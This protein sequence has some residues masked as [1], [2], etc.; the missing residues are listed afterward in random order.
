MD[1]IPCDVADVFQREAQQ[2]TKRRAA[3]EII[4]AF[5]NS[6]E[7]CVEI[8]DVPNTTMMAAYQMIRREMI[9]L[10]LWDTHT[11]NLR[12]GRLYLRK[13]GVLR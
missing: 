11:A 7:T 13:R 1:M 12:E 2:A 4:G 10:G 5:L 6:G 9:R 3:A 8:T